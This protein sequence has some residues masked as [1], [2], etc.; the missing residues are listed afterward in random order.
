MVQNLVITDPYGRP[1]LNLRIAVN[2]ACNLACFFCH[3]EGEFKPLKCYKSIENKELSMEQILS[4]V[5]IAA[6]YGVREVKI[7]GGEPLLRNDIIEIVRG[8]SSI[9]GI[10]EV[11]MVTNGLLLEKTAWRL[12]DA[13]LK[14]ANVSLHSL[15]PEVYSKITGYRKK[16]GPKR[17][18]N[19]VIEGINAGLD[20]VKINFVVLKGLNNDEIEKMIGLSGELGI[21]VQ[22]IEY[23][24][25]KGFAS[26]VFRKYYYPLSELEEALEKRAER[27]RVRKMH[28]RKRYYLS[29]GAEIEVVRPMFNPGFCANCTRLRVTS[30]GEFKPC[31]MRNDNH[32]KFIHVFNGENSIEK[33]KVL[34]E[35]AVKRREPYYKFPMEV[36]VF[37]ETSKNG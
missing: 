13:G 22:F 34:F 35:E 30:E 28:N 23:H 14:R 15:K 20:P 8:I 2:S 19:G 12:K 37:A 36:D 11:S 32:V 4:V 7:T 24:E 18:L 17:V 9:K 33:L 3:G 31:L 27:I 10:E 25:P 6:N 5:E 16:D 21:P 26:P 1:V 29:N